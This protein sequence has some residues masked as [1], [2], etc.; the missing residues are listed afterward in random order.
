[1][2]H[3]RSMWFPTLNPYSPI[4]C[5]PPL[6]LLKSPLPSSSSFRLAPLK[7]KDCFCVFL[8]LRSSPVDNNEDYSRGSNMISVLPLLSPNPFTYSHTSSAPHS[9]HSPSSTT[10]Y[11]LLTSQGTTKKNNKTTTTKNNRSLLTWHKD[12][13]SFF[14]FSDFIGIEY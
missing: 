8:L 4:L 3:S 11:P 12:F 14:Y 2:I 5:A 1:M 6:L 13:I 10:P 9:P 7:R